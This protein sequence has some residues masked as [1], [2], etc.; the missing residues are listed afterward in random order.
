[1]IKDRTGTLIFSGGSGTANS[2]GST[3]VN[4]GTLVLDKSIANVSIPG[5]LT[6]GDGAGG[7]NSDIVRLAGIIRSRCAAIMMQMRLGPERHD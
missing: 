1:L 3:I 5:A 7:L 4:D 2:Y 6:I